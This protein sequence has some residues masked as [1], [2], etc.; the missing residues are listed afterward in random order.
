MVEFSELGN[1]ECPDWNDFPI[2]VNDGIGG[3]L[4]TNIIICGGHTPWDVTDDCYAISAKKAELLMFKMS[5]PRRLAASITINDTALWI[6][7]GLTPNLPPSNSSEFVTIDGTT[8]GNV[9]T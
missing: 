8:P 5:T 1:Y 9:I 2:R 3:L 7:G 4:G 6:T